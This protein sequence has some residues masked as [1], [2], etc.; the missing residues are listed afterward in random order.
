ML[1]INRKVLLD[2]TGLAEEQ[3]PKSFLGL[4]EF[5]NPWAA[6]SA[7]A[8][9]DSEPLDRSAARRLC[10]MFIEQYISY[11]EGSGEPLVFDTALF[12]AGLALRDQV[13]KLPSVADEGAWSDVMGCNEEP[14]S[15][16]HAPGILPLPLDG[17]H[18]YTLSVALSLLFVNPNSPNM[19]L[20][21]AYLKSMIRNMP[22]EK[23]VLW[24][25]GDR[26]PVPN[27]EYEAM[28]AEYAKEVDAL[29]AKATAF[30]DDEDPW[31][32]GDLEYDLTE[33]QEEAANFTQHGR[34]LVSPDFLQAYGLLSGHMVVYEQDF[35][36]SGYGVFGH[37]LAANHLREQYVQGQIDADALIAGL[38][39]VADMRRAAEE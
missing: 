9:A 32:A 31:L 2:Q 11:Y 12:R 38:Q 29:R 5:L 22:P 1:E 10:E 13:P 20:A 30:A 4:P 3:L 14:L 23:R 17:K 33:L 15:A 7:Q 34:W 36:D 21:I 19:D 8:N 18:P 28:L 24:M 27:P 37:A 25:P 35:F 39:R 16:S 6:Q 26:Q